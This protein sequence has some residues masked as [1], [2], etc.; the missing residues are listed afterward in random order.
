MA[1]ID[2]LEAKLDAVLRPDPPGRRRVWRALDPPPDDQVSAGIEKL[3]AVGLAHSGLSCLR[4]IRGRAACHILPFAERCAAHALNVPTH[5]FSPASTVET[6]VDEQAGAA[7]DSAAARAGRADRCSLRRRCAAQPS[8]T[9]VEQLEQVITDHLWLADSIARRFLGRGQEADDLIQVARSGLVE[10]VRRFDPEQ[11]P[12]IAFAV[13]TITGVVKRHFRD[14]GWFVRPPRRTQELA[15]RIRSEWPDL[16]QQLKSEPSGDRPRGTPDRVPVRRPG[17]SARRTVVRIEFAGR[18]GGRAASRSPAPPARS[19]R[20]GARRACCWD[21]PGV[22]LTRSEQRLLWMRFY[23]EKSQ[24]E[25]ASRDRHEPDAGLAAAGPDAAT[26][27]SPDRDR[28][29][30]SACVLAHLVSMTAG[31]QQPHPGLTGRMREKP[32][33]GEASY[34]GSGRLSGKRAVITGGDSGIGRAVALAFAR[35]GADVCISYLASEETDA[36]ETVRL[37]E[38]AGR[39]AVRC[40]GDIRDEA[41]L[42]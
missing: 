11:G 8:R 35:E 25:I 24:S 39:K 15:A 20:T 42:S 32:D 6:V 38:A 2:R 3:P 18:G 34:R 1:R 27:A 37:I 22:H 14:H 17:S 40:P 30:D 31:E 23:E 19:S 4:C 28:R 7:A 33:H 16:V 13:P 21:G 26:V 29:R 41:D 9:A 10:A 5:S 12:F 36:D